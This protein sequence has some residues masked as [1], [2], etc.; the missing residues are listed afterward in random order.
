M[1]PMETEKILIGQRQLQRWHLIKMVGVGKITFPFLT[2][3][4]ASPTFPKTQSLGD[5]QSG[6][7]HLLPEGLLNDIPGNLKGWARDADRSNNPASLVEFHNT[8]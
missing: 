2:P 4:C 1:F 3:N 5:K 7:H 6:F 8:K